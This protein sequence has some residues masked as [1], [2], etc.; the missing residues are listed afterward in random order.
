MCNFVLE[1]MAY[2]ISKTNYWL[3]KGSRSVAKLSLVEKLVSS[4]VP[5]LVELKKSE[6]NYKMFE[7]YC[8]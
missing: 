5:Q 7:I 6:K 1:S 8:Y 3:S 2:L 4:M